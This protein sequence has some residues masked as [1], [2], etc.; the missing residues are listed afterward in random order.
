V[1][2]GVRIAEQPGHR[3]ER[4]H[5]HLPLLQAQNSPADRLFH[6]QLGRCEFEFGRALPHMTRESLPCTHS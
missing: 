4:V 3:P 5:C 6:H 2:R 1:K